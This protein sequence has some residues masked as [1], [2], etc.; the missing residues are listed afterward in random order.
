MILLRA[1]LGDLTIRIMLGL[2]G[3]HMRKGHLMK[4]KFVIFLSRFLGSHCPIEEKLSTS[5]VHQLSLH[6]NQVQVV[7]LK[8]TTRKDLGPFLPFLHNLLLP[9]SMS[10]SKKSIWFNC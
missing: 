2:G 7:Y 8:D 4:H 9:R 5:W 6:L 1:A 10:S 3:D